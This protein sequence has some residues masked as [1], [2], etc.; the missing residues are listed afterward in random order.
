M[1]DNKAHNLG[2]VSLEVGKAEI[3]KFE[4]GPRKRHRKSKLARELR[5]LKKA[6]VPVAGATLTADGSISLTFGEAVKSPGNELDDWVQRRNHESP[7]KRN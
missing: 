3:G 7:T 4:T 5:E 2:A 1:V 6:G